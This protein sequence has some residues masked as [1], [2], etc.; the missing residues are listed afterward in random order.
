M[1][2]K[3]TLTWTVLRQSGEFLSTMN[4]EKFYASISSIKT[5][6]DAA[7]LNL[8]LLSTHQHYLRR[9]SLYMLDFFFH[10]YTTCNI[11]LS[12]KSINAQNPLQPLDIAFT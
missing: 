3:G 4:G 6:L 8:I 9:A 12:N 5:R 10:F 7:N 11:L 2:R 1:H